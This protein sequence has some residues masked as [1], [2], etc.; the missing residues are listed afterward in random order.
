MK[1]YIES[2]YIEDN[3]TSVATNSPSIIR[4]LKTLSEEPASGYKLLKQLKTKTYF[5]VPLS[6]AE[7]H[8]GLGADI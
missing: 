4:I 3:K 7:I 5:I 8:K 6:I 1:Y 2:R